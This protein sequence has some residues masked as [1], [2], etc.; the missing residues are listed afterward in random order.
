MGASGRWRAPASPAAD[1]PLLSTPSAR[2]CC[3]RRRRA[4]ASPA[5]D[6]PLIPPPLA[7]PCCPCHR[8]APASPAAERPDSPAAGAPPDSP[9]DGA[10]AVPAAARPCFPRRR[11]L[12]LPPSACPCT[13]PRRR[14]GGSVLREATRGRRAD[15]RRGASLGRL[16]GAAGVTEYALDFNRNSLLVLKISGS[17][18]F[19]FIVAT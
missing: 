16:V 6:T 4:P 12:L 2:L 14:G 17:D 9:A 13:L 15:A 7:R 11:A 19:V 3:P 8:C 18:F 1:A 10:S 5:A